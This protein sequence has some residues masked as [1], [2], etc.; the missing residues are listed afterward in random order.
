MDLLDELG[1]HPHLPAVAY[2]PLWRAARGHEPR[3]RAAL[4]A[5]LAAHP[6]TPTGMRSG[7]ADDRRVSVRA[8][9]AAACGDDVLLERLA[10][11]DSGAVRAAVAS[12]PAAGARLLGRLAADADHRVSVAACMQ[13]VCPGAAVVGALP[14]LARPTTPGYAHQLDRTVVWAAL[15]QRPAVV[16]HLLESDDS[17]A[18]RLGAEHIGL[19]D[20]AR[21]RAAGLAARERALPVLQALAAAPGVDLD[22]VGLPPT[23]RRVHQQVQAWTAG[24][25]L[26][27]VC[28]VPQRRTQGIALGIDAV[29]RALA[30]SAGGHDVGVALEELAVACQR[31]PPPDA[32]ARWTVR[33][34]EADRDL[35]P[36]VEGLLG[37]LGDDRRRAVEHAAGE[38]AYT[39]RPGRRAEVLIRHLGDDEVAWDS[40]L[41]LAADWE[42]AADGL[43]RV[44]VALVG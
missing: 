30:A 8:G 19:L 3:R 44:A 39:W 36:N 33:L 35:W 16:V 37:R 25:D 26:A 32:V 38:H 24:D 34:L 15:A 20:D 2:G 12:N 14:G 41:A 1:R 10:E 4:H 29:D 7:W 22:G 27:E 28:A 13:P 21:Q 9:V 18:R 5:R 40:A 11:D 31:T 43:G 6:T 23:A 17:A 42:G